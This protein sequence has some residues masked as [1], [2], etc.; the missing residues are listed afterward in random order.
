MK[1]PN[2]GFQIEYLETV[3]MALSEGRSEQPHQM[4][5]GHGVEDDGLVSKK[6]VAHA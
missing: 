4:C 1:P 6:I 2:F 5:C 3:G